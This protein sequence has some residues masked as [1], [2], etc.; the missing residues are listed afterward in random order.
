ME[1]SSKNL[2][3][4]EKLQNCSKKI[5]ETEKLLS[6]L[7]Y[8]NL[9]ESIEYKKLLNHLKKLI[10]EENEI[11]EEIDGNHYE[12]TQLMFYISKKENLT[13]MSTQMYIL[14][15]NIEEKIIQCRILMKLRELDLE[16][17]S[18]EFEEL[19]KMPVIDLTKN[20]IS[21]NSKQGILMIDLQIRKDIINT[22]FH[23]L[24][25]VIKEMENIDYRKYLIR[26]K[27]SMITMFKFKEDDVINNKFTINTP[28]YWLASSTAYYYS[29]NNQLF[30]AYK[31]EIIADLGMFSTFY[32]NDLDYQ[33][34]EKTKT[35]IEAEFYKIILRVAN[36]FKPLNNIDDLKFTAEKILKQKRASE[37]STEGERI[38]LETIK[39]AK[40]DHTLPKSILIKIRKKES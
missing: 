23:L 40:E 8:S 1:I 20:R 26:I 39:H 12:I 22:I 19:N 16:V 33:H 32:F 14:I 15:K 21:N 38:I 2:E 3:I 17:N 10:E 9:Q 18:D 7:E 27:Y 31:N 34:F 5:L 25:S 29:I 30:E 35:L 13:N 28:L 6:S 24:N 4:T 11:Y 36:M 37:I